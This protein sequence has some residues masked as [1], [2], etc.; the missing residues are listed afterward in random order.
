MR[1]RRS[2][3]MSAARLPWTAEGNAVLLRVLSAEG[4]IHRARR[5][6]YTFNDVLGLNLAQSL[7]L[8]QAFLGGLPKYRPERRALRNQARAF[9]GEATGFC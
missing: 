2:I 6:S 8:D 7:G 1:R 4:V 3:S 9:G 5:A